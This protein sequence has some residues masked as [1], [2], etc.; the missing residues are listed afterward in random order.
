MRHLIRTFSLL[1]FL[2][3]A[4]LASPTPSSPPRVVAEIREVSMFLVHTVPHQ[5][6]V[7]IYEDGQVESFV[8]TG[9]G[10]TEDQLAVI[11]Q[12][13][14]TQMIKDIDHLTAG[15]FRETP[16]RTE[17]CFSMNKIYFNVFNSKGEKIVLRDVIKCVQRDLEK[18]PQA[19][20]IREVL[21]GMS[22]LRAF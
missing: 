11:S 12:N 8:I 21:A 2:P 14:V 13:K 5:S 4:S 9:Y 17:P 18:Q 1:L 7:R 10:T 3:A 19:D 15:E 6:G 22:S 16:L 20:Q